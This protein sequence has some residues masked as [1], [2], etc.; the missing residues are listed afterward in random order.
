ME[1]TI[2]SALNAEIPM[3]QYLSKSG[4]PVSGVTPR[5]FEKMYSTLIREYG[6]TTS[7]IVEASSYSMAMVV[8]AALGLSAAGGRICA[9]ATDSLS[10]WIALA[11]MRHLANGGADPLVVLVTPSNQLSP[12][13]DQQ[14]KPLGKM[15]V[16]IFDWSPSGD[17]GEL[18]KLLES[19]HNS[20][21]GVGTPGHGQADF[22]KPLIN[23]LND[24]PTP[25]HCIQSPLGL[26]P[27]SGA[28]RGSAVFASS[29]LSLGIPL[30]G[31][32]Q[33]REHV[34]RHYVCDISLVRQQYIEEGQDLTLLFADQPVVQ[35]IPSDEAQKIS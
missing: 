13:I 18:T 12:E 14:L 6:I 29:T 11:T 33:G 4:I 22:Q 2:P 3:A 9:L 1:N 27:E 7:Q 15:G 21:L 30:S 8:R 16:P 25:L 10:G 5:V 24:L 34:G 35:L 26:D 28:Q 32:Y 31:L 23:V 19:C 20:I 17:E